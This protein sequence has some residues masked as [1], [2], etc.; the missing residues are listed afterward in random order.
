MQL[1]G[2]LEMITNRAKPEFIHTMSQIN[3]Q[4]IDS[5]LNPYSSAFDLFSFFPFFIYFFLKRVSDCLNNFG[6]ELSENHWTR[7]IKYLKNSDRHCVISKAPSQNG[8]EVDVLINCR[9]TFWNHVCS[10]HLKRKKKN[11]TLWILL[12]IFL[13]S[14]YPVPMLSEKKKQT[15]ENLIGMDK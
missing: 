6:R 9:H 1:Y 7:F 3:Q 4:F 5:K 12:W 14:L 10:L 8:R 2:T 15:N 13:A 11:G